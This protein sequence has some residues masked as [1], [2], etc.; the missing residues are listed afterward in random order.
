MQVQC[1]VPFIWW[2]LSVAKPTLLCLDLSQE[3]KNESHWCVL[4][5]NRRGT[6]LQFFFLHLNTG[7]SRSKQNIWSLW[8]ESLVQNMKHCKDPIPLHYSTKNTR[9]NGAVRYGLNGNLADPNNVIILLSL[10]PNLIHLKTPPFYNH[11]NFVLR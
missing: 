9:A 8:L 1:C 7:I 4:L 3:S 6:S 11:L 5:H 10:K 2:I